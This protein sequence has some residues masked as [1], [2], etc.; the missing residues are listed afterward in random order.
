LT[1]GVICQASSGGMRRMGLAFFAGVALLMGSF[2]QPTLEKIRADLRTD[3]NSSWF[4]LA[5]GL[6]D[7][8]VGS[9]IASDDKTGMYVSLMT[10]LPFFG[11]N[12]EATAAD[13]A[14]SNADLIIIGRDRV[15][16]GDLARRADMKEVIFTNNKALV[17]P[18]YRVFQKTNVNAPNRAPTRCREGPG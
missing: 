9:A 13:F 12:S 5:R 2:I 4:P 7:L 6:R 1:Y 16:A 11:I 3:P 18:N 17:N 10:G 8:G 14:G 15:V